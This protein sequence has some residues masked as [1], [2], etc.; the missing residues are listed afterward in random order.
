MRKLDYYLSGQIRSCKP[1]GWSFRKFKVVTNTK[2]PQQ[3][4]GTD[5]GIYV[6]SFMEGRDMHRIPVSV[7]TNF[8]ILLFLNDAWMVINN[9]RCF[10]LYRDLI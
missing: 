7:L 10:K 8:I 5:C 2:A 1:G 4:N 6:I 3:T 9:N